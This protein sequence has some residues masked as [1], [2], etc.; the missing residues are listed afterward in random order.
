[1]KKVLKQLVL[2]TLKDYKFSDYTRKIL[3]H[4]LETN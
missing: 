3:N 1:M 4:V 2:D